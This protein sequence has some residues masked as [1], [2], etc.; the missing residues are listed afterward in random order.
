MYKILVFCVVSRCDERLLFR[1]LSAE[2]RSLHGRHRGEQRARASS[3]F[4]AAHN[5]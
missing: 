3:R 2:P 1:L 5:S 4:A